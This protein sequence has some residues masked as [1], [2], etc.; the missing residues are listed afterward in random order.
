MNGYN[1]QEALPFIL[2]RIDARIH[3][4]LPL[5]LTELV[6][7]AIDADLEFMR[8]SGV[9]D[10]NGNAGTAYYDDDD[11][12]EYMLD[13]LVSKSKLGA[14]AAMKVASLL[15]DYMDAQ[16]AFLEEKGLV[17]WD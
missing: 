2:A 1:K 5:T 8:K 17:D 14:D 6:S 3:K 13:T 9:L 10:E 16:Q 11:A 15:D 7:Q 12:F 4:E